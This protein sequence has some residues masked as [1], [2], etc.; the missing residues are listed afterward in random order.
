MKPE[1]DWEK[2]ARLKREKELEEQYRIK[3]NN[4]DYVK[5]I[6][7]AISGSPSYGAADNYLSP[8]NRN[9]LYRTHVLQAYFITYPIDRPISVMIDHSRQVLQIQPSN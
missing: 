7:G 8:T 1:E 9:S 2:E 3:T 4:F 6:V 5:G